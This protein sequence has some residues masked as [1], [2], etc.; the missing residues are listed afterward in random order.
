M[1]NQ[2][3]RLLRGEEIESFLSSLQ[4]NRESTSEQ[5]DTAVAEILQRVRREGDGAL[6]EL[7]ARFD[8]VDLR[9]VGLRVDRAELEELAGTV[10]A[11]TVEALRRAADNIRAFHERQVPESWLVCREAGVI[12]GEKITPLHRVG[13]YVPGGTAAYPSTLLMTAIPAQVAGVEEIAVCTAPGRQ[14]RISPLVAAAVQLLG[15]E[16]VYRVGGAQA[17]AALAYG[18]ETIPPVDKVFGP[19]NAYVTAAKKQV[20][21]RVGID[22]LA[23]PSEVVLLAD[24]TA[25]PAF[26]A[27]D[28]LAQAEHDPLSV[29]VLVTPDAGLAADV[30]SELHAQLVELPRREIA[31]QSLGAQGAILVTEDLVRAVAVVNR[32]AP[33][34][35]G[36]HTEDPWALLGQIRNAGSIYLGSFAPEAVGDYWAG[37]N[38]VLPTGGSARFS[39]ALTVEDYVKRSNVVA[40]TREGLAFAA[41]DVV[42]LAKAEGLVAH[43]RAV[44]V[45]TKNG[46]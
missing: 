23:G 10:P 41:D 42:R 39:S 1:R 24:G 22:M 6:F 32:I 40:Y 9:D 19:G 31:E 33:E 16:E 26:V 25:E 21:G 35:L 34:H 36:I 27:A 5:I 7:T 37:P 20:F 13:L 12:L 44:T 15:L 14:G 17:V 8:G 30:Q 43:A 45:R 4:Q 46:N 29:A 38:H 2:P 18:T 28:L 3:I 11:E